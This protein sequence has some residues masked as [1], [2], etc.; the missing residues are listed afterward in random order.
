[1]D[2]TVP[3]RVLSMRQRATER[4]GRM[5]DVYDVRN[6]ETSRVLPGMFPD[7]WPK[8]IV[9]NF[10]DVVA[11]DLA[12]VTGITPSINCESA[13]QVSNRAKQFASKRTKIAHYYFDKSNLKTE[14]NTAADRYYTY[15]FVPFIVE[16][17]FDHYCPHILVDDPMGT[18]YTLDLMGN[19]SAYVKVW[20]ETALDLIAKFPAHRDAI[21]GKDDPWGSGGDQHELEVVRYIDKNTQV[22]YIPEK[23][24]LVLLELP[25]RLGKVNVVIA[26]RPGL[27]DQT[28]GQFDDA[29]W[30]QLA[31]ARM[32]LLGLEAVEKSVQAPLA[33]PSDVQQMNF[34]PD[35]II[36][37][38][39]PEKI[40]RVGIELPSGAFAENEMLDRDLRE[41]TRYPA[42]RTGDIDASVVTGRGVQALSS[43]FDSQVKT[44]QNAIGQALA[45][46]LSLCLEMDE[47]YWPSRVKQ[48][49]GVANGAHYEET[50]TPQKDIAGVYTVDVTYGFAAG[51]DPNRALVFLLQLRG[52]K[53]V[54]RDF[55]QRQLPMDI[56]VVQLQQQVDNE[57]TTDALKQGVYSML[58][59]MGIMAQQ[60]LDPT[61][62]LRKTASIIAM[63]E[64]GK[65]FHEAVLE[66]FVPPEQ[67]P[68]GGSIPGE[69]A[70]A[71]GDGSSSPGGLPPGM[72]A[73]GLPFG[74]APGQAE[75]GQG[76]RP[77]MQ[78]LLA[79]LGSSGQANLSAGVARRLPA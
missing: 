25:N 70:T 35:A 31:R 67:P 11:R 7:I 12:D 16:P 55:V 54:P 38:A 64:K 10:I 15:G 78:T 61:D 48:I 52:D 57:E 51:M 19:V 60:G 69:P 33:L 18:Y 72:Q 49:R 39:S 1:M 9:S 17:D 58:A 4:D 42:S 41:G 22:L 44:A 37:T 59:S 76:G 74:I 2:Q 46:A 75:M 65:S 26:E 30:V 43:G 21:L 53:L 6:G 24:D 28:R 71:T 14:L 63:R 50:Y 3:R 47:T 40:K 23:K 32:A 36:R 56:D 20:R 5:H 73:S 45:R 66:A 34:G 27:D 8:P 62:I 79:S 13:L 29:I 77:D 68:G